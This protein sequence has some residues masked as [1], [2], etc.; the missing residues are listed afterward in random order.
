MIVRPLVG[1]LEENWAKSDPN[2]AH[3]SGWPVF[4]KTGADNTS[5]TYF[6]IDPGKHIGRHTHD[7]DETI[8]L[9]DGAA[10]AEVGDEQASVEPWTLVHVPQGAV[11]DVFNE[12]SDKLRLVGFFSKATVTTTFEQVQMPD[13][14]TKLGT[15]D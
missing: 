13:D 12:G 10:R 2:V 6:E 7:A 11:H 5:I 14:S 1:D 15:P 4:S 3:R 8:L 9:L